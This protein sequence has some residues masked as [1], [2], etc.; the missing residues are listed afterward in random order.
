MENNRVGHQ[1]SA[2]GC[3]R[4]GDIKDGPEFK[5]DEI[6]HKAQPETVYLVADGT[7][8]KKQQ[9]RLYQLTL[10][11][12]PALIVKEKKRDD[13]DD[14]DAGNYLDGEKLVFE[15]AE[16]NA[17]ILAVHYLEYPGI[18]KDFTSRQIIPDPYLGQLVGYQ[19]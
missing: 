10:E 14:T 17:G 9:C 7:A 16:D 13:E 3:H 12:S 4:I 5:V 15:Q 18:E 11:K 2:D 19:Q 8:K 6:G 1:D